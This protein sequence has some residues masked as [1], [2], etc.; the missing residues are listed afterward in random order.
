MEF[1]QL[2]RNRQ[3]VRRYEPAPVD[4]ETILECIEAARL[5]PSASNSQPWHFIVVDDPALKAGIAQAAWED[6]LVF[7]RFASK[8]PVIVVMVT[9]KGTWLSRLG[10]SLKERDFSLIDNGIAAIQFCL[11]ASELGLGTCMIG[12]FNQKKIKKLLG[13]PDQKFLSLLITLGYPEH[14][15]RTRE[16]TRKPVGRIVSWNGYHSNSKL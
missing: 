8:A 16:K 4:R 6:I 14:G 7:N 12:W 1:R 2:I 3:S 5:A 9:E 10:A 11:R 13:I 15:Y